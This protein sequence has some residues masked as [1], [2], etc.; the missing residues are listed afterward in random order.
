MGSMVFQLP[1]NVSPECEADLERAC[2]AGGQDG[3]PFPTHVNLEPG[4]LFVERGIN[5]SGFL[6]VPWKV[7]GVGRLML[8][9]ATLMERRH[10][11]D[12][13]LELSRGK[14]HQLRNQMSEWV[15]GGLILPDEVQKQIQAATHA[16]GKAA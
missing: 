5:E 10:P 13:L 9:S 6:S 8:N 15:G 2:V 4:L 3:M 11:Y 14:I 1:A 7:E 16:F 12:L